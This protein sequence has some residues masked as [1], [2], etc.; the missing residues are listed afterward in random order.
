MATTDVTAAR[1]PTGSTPAHERWRAARTVDDASVAAAGVAVVLALLVLPPIWYLLYGSVHTTLPD[2]SPGA[3]TLEYFARLFSE[4]RLL[5]SAINSAIFA[6][7][8]AAL[9]IVLG[10]AQAWIV[11]RTNA[12]FKTLAYLG[13]FISLAIPYIL[14]VVAWL[15]L[16][17]R[18]GPINDLVRLLLGADRPPLRVESMWGMILIEGLLWT[19]LAFLM[20]CSTFR[21]ANTTFEEAAMT[22]GA[23]TW[24]TLRHVTFRLATPA[25][26]ALALL[27]FIRGIEAFE[28]PALV[29]LSGRINVLTT[30]IFLSLKM[31]TRP[32]LGRA[33]AFAV[34]LLLVVSILLYFYGRIAKSAAK[35]QTVTGKGYRPRL[36]DLGRACWLAAAA[37]VL[38][39][40]VVVVLPL[41][42]LAWLS[43]MPFSQGVSMRGMRTAT[44]E[45]YRIALSSVSVIRSAWNTLILSFAAAS[46]IMIMAALTGWLVARRRPGA[47][48]LDQLGTMPLI[49]P[50]IVLA[51]AMMQVFLSL[52]LP[53]YGTIWIL[54]IAFTTRYLPYGLRYS[55]AGVVQIHS[56]LEEVAGTSGA[57]PMRSFR[58]VVLPL[59]GPALA[60]GWMFIFL[61]TA[62]DLSM[63]VLLAGPAS[64]V[65]AV[66]L[67]ELWT[68]GQATELAAFGLM[69][70]ALMS[71]LAVGFYLVAERSGI[72]VY[73]N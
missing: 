56:E 70:T 9:A 46:V 40:L 41:L 45:N 18:N 52:P 54:L 2:G 17:G 6:V 24:A 43:L 65:V 58:H 48:L 19:P 5:E 14:Y 33:S 62:R 57:S 22:C 39:F 1:A 55:F 63:P 59:L 61:M 8:S 73:G 3:F 47:W 34:V 38:I 69:W 35:Y 25:L 42:A 23:T 60:A 28:V 53:I 67:F 12:P 15:F 64:Q 71:A 30:E 44:F 16:F 31:Q 51:V 20:L 50:G 10:G 21:A 72:S 13:A 49:F 36:M 11:E 26:L 27:V 4:P 29:G 37:T 68:N 32:D 7:G 66:E